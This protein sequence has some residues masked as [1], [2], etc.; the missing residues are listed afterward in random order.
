MRH[1]NKK[2]IINFVVGETIFNQLTDTN[3]N[4]NYN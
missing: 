1:L 3:N 2:L 4:F